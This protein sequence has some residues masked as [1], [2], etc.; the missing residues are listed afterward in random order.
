[1]T[2]GAALRGRPSFKQDHFRGTG[3]HGVPPLQ[4]HRRF[5]GDLVPFLVEGAEKGFGLLVL[6]VEGEE[7]VGIASDFGSAHLLGDIVEA[8]FGA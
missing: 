6:A 3:G 4:L 2:V 1:L 5:L 8:L 7:A